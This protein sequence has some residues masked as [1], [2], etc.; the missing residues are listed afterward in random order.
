MVVF[1]AALSNNNNDPATG[2]R[3]HQYQHHHAS[4]S[5]K[6]DRFRQPYNSSTQDV[7]DCNKSVLSRC[8][9]DG[10]DEDDVFAS[11]ESFRDSI[12]NGNGNAVDAN[13]IRRQPISQTTTIDEDSTIGGGVSN[14]STPYDRIAQVAQQLQQEQLRQQREQQQ[15]QPTTPVANKSVRVKKQRHFD[16]LEYEESS[17]PD[18]TPPPKS[19][20]SKKKSPNSIL[21]QRNHLQSHQYSGQQQ[22]QQQPWHQ[23][24]G[25]DEQRHHPDD[26]LFYPGHHQYTAQ[27]TKGKKNRVLDND[28]ISLGS[29]EATQTYRNKYKN[30]LPMMF[31]ATVSTRDNG[32]D[33]PVGVGRITTSRSSSSIIESFGMMGDNDQNNINTGDK[34][35]GNTNTDARPS[36]SAVVTPEKQQE[37]QQQNQRKQSSASPSDYIKAKLVELLFPESNNGNGTGTRMCNMI[38]LNVED[39]ERLMQLLS[40]GDDAETS[41]ARAVAAR[42]GSSNVRASERVAKDGA[43][44]DAAVDD[45]LFLEGV[46]AGGCMSTAIRDG[47]DT[48]CRCT[49]MGAGGDDD[50][51]TDDNFDMK[52]ATMTSMFKQA[53]NSFVASGTPKIAY[54]LLDRFGVLES[55]ESMQPNKLLEACE[56][57]GC[58][59]EDQEEAV[60]A[61]ITSKGGRDAS[62]KNSTNVA[63]RNSNSNIP[64]VNTRDKPIRRTSDI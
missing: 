10:D 61:E 42:S 63:R 52:N 34:T 20:T 15:Q 51:S 12:Q 8:T 6:I 62:E 21:K 36:R 45:D 26:E 58:E 9:Y 7:A 29:A 30:I 48:L 31:T 56:G 11:Y 24:Y 38:E 40:V 23:K 53:H 17:G 43:N 46:G 60:A 19:R 33:G 5:P 50:D 14:P 39:K 13:S 44:G 4:N 1:Q 55:I 47:L 49:T 32:I 37:Q 54:G 35:V 18:L 41:T 16:G 27:L 59:D 28:D 25:Q 57:G 22:Q 3:R 64:G 2:G